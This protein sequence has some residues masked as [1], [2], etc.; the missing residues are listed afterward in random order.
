[1]EAMQREVLDLLG[2]EATRFVVPA[3]Q[4]T[5]SWGTEQCEELW[6][7]II[8]AGRAERNHF[9]GTI[10]CLEAAAEPSSGS[11]GREETR[12]FEVVDGQQRITTVS[13]IIAAL[14][15]RLERTGGSAGPFAHQGLRDRFLRFTTTGAPRLMPSQADRAAYET[16]V[17]DGL[18][19]CSE[20]FPSSRICANLA[21]FCERMSQEGFEVRTLWRGLERL[22]AIEVGV[23]DAHGAQSVF[24]GVNSKGVPLNVADMVRNYLLLAEGHEE[25]TRLYEEYWHPLEG[26]FAPDPGSLRLDTAIKSWLAIRLKGARIRSPEQV[27]SSFK[28]FVEDEYR[29]DKEPILRELRGFGLMWAENYRYHGVK[30]YKTASSWAELGAPALTAGYEL[31][32]PDNEEYAARVRAELDRVD[33]RW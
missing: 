18:Q 24:E 32:K 5:Y 23:D 26:M 13:L 31:R 25:Q 12:T 33:A 27:Y 17:S 29:G 21:F 7:D 2:E 1:M 16:A 9:L 11:D 4:R 20:A 28:R 10:L 22:V 30:K 6:L 14:A 19:A 3:Y 8:R 15:D